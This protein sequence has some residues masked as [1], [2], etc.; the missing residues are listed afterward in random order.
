[1]TRHLNGDRS[2]ANAGVDDKRGEEAWTPAEHALLDAALAF[3]GAAEG[4]IDYAG[5]RRPQ[6]RQDAAGFDAVRRAMAALE[7]RVRSARAAGVTPERIAQV[8]RIDE[9]MVS[10]ILQREPAAPSSTEG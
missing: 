3:Y 9:E 2:G 7:D 6:V 8:A 5:R 1:V 10:L 4:V